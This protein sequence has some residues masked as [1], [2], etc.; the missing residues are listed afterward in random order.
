VTGSV[1]VH[2]EVF[3]MIDD[4]IEFINWISVVFELYFEYVW[5]C[6]QQQK[7]YWYWFI[8]GIIISSAYAIPLSDE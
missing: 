4:V 6:E 1:L 8:F 5:A 3:L 2:L 7:V